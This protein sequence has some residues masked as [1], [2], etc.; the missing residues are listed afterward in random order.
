MREIK[1]RAWHKDKKQMIKGSLLYWFK[2]CAESGKGESVFDACEWMQF[3]GLKDKD[4]TEIYEGDVLE[5]RHCRELSKAEC[6][7]EEGGFQFKG[8]GCS[9]C[10]EELSNNILSNFEVIGNIWENPELL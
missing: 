1:Y 8:T 10:D 4:G 2:A 3:T 6:F 9:S 5:N 7:F